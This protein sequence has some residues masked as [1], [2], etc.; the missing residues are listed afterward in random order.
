MVAP[1]D[2]RVAIAVAGSV[3]QAEQVIAAVHRRPGGGGRGGRRCTVVR[4]EPIPDADTAY[5]AADAEGR[6]LDLSRA[7]SMRTWSYRSGW[8]W[9]AAIGGRSLAGELWPTF[10]GRDPG[11]T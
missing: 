1:G 6:P 9:D 8:Q 7:W 11:S 4:D 3:P 10:S 2:R 5:L